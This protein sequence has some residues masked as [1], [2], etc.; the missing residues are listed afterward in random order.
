M[1]A[2]GRRIRVGVLAGGA[3]AERQISLLTGAQVASALP[4]ERYEVVLLDPLALMVGNPKLTDEQRERAR[5][6]LT[7]GPHDAV[8]ASDAQLPADLRAAVERASSALVPATSAFGGASGE[9]RLD[10]AFIALHGPWGEDGRIQGVLDTLGVPYTGSGVLAS[11]LAMDK[12][13]A[14]TVLAAAGLDVPRGTVVRAPEEALPGARSFGPPWVVKPVASGSSFGVS[15]VDEERRLADAV[16]EALAYDDRAMVEERLSG[17][18]LTCGVIGNDEPEALPVI[19]IVPKRAFFDYRAKYDPA[20]SDEICPARI[21]DELARRVQELSLRAHRALGCR[22]LSRTDLIAA[23]DRLPVLEVN[24]MPGMTANSLLPKA[25]R[26]AGI[27]FAEL[28]ERLVRWAL[29][30]ARR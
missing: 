30:D 15:L 1:S 2:G 22:G 8:D 19:E 24:T 17:T 12:V 18:E 3:S 7:G 16:R 29:E 13:M 23:G 5:A 21:P 6:L 4:A 11:A 14:K 28:V 26:V 9:T 25:A 10:V 20:A 27:S